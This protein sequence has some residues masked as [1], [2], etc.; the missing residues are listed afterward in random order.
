MLLCGD[1]TDQHDVAR[2]M[3]GKKA[4]LVATDPPYLVDYTGD[5]PNDAGKDWSRDY[6]EIDIGDAHPFYR[7]VFENVLSVIAPHAA[8]YCWHAHKRQAALSRAWEELGILDHQ[9]IIWVKPT[10]V[11]GRC[12]WHFRHEPCMMGWVSGSIPTHD[13]SHE[14]DSVWEIDWEGKQRLVGN[15]HPTQKPLEIFLRPM[16]KHTKRGAIVFEPFSGSGSQ[17]IAAEQIGRR[18]R[19]IEISPA[20]VDVAILRWQTA[21]G[22]HAILDGTPNRFSNVAATR[23]KE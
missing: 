12:F 18:C 22:E 7:A 19:A 23:Q 4:S 8:I 10:P 16:R 13:G 14:H 9:Q 20:F 21:T 6:R 17:L 15:E 2:V 3:W 1:A 5:R 11:F